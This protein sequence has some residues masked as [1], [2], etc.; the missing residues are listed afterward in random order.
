MPKCLDPSILSP[1]VPKKYWDLHDPAKLPQPTFKKPPEGAPKQAGKR[2]GEIVQFKPIP[3]N[4]DIDEKLTRQLI[5]G[6]YACT[7]YVDAQI[8][9][10]IDGLDGLGLSENTIIVLW[11]DHGW[12]LGDHDIWTK[13]TNY[14]QANRIPLLIIAPGVTKPKQSTKQLAETVDL[15]P[16]LAELAGLPKPEVPQNID[17]TSLVPVLHDPAARVR[18]HAYH[19]YPRDGIGRAIRTER[20]RLVEWKISG[21]PPETAEIEL[22]DYQEDPLETKNHAREKPEIVAELRAILAKHPEAKPR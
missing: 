20:Y 17:G 3:E 11:G 1:A 7:S 8:G 9:R 15:Y 2:G 5:H 22:Y 14:E 12:H 16:T 21:K 10:L 6:Y 4:V 13:H 19:C 18:D